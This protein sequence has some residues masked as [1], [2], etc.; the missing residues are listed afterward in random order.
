MVTLESQIPTHR[1]LHRGQFEH[2]LRCSTEASPQLNAFYG[3]RFH[4]WAR[5]RTYIRKQSLEARM[6]SNMK[7]KFGH[8]ISIVLGDWSGGNTRSHQPSKVK[9]WR[10]TFRCHGLRR[11]L[12]DECRTSALCPCCEERVVSAFKERPHSRPY[13]R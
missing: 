8:D 2:Y 12:L 5:F 7:K 6:V 3:K 10:T 1:P 11:F 13:R 4:A 9:G